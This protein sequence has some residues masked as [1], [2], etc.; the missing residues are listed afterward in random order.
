[1]S[2][3]QAYAAWLDHLT[4]ERRASPRTVR[5]YGD[6]VLAYLNFLEAHRG[7]ALSLSALAEISAADLRGYLAWRRQGEHALAPRSLSQALS[8]I[9]AFHRYLDQRH[10]VA[11]AAVDLVRGPRL[12]IGLPRPVSED[13]ARD[14]IT[15]AA[16]D[17]ERDPWE[18]ARDEAVLTLLWGCGLRIS[19][20]LSLRMSDA[21]LAATLRITG[22]GGKTRIV[23]VLDAVRDA[24]EAYLD[25]LPFNLAP[26]EALFRAKRGGPLSPR[27]V[28][29]LVQTLRGRLGLSD[30]VTPHAFRHAFATHLLGAGADLRAIQDLLGHASLSTTQRYTQ[31]DAAGLLA[32]YQAAHPKG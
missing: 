7:E 20:A 14:L 3:R 12:K 30:R 2:A 5:A 17:T 26:D 22:K 10:G 15:Q 6:N 13:Q 8:S 28:Q 31:V 1:M 11:N 21:P 18:T 27:H 19:E 4:L 32:A 29:G 24:I 16:E 25:E 23:P 9:R